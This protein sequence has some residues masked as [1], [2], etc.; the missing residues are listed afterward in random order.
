MVIPKRGSMLYLCFLLQIL[1]LVYVR[2]FMIHSVSEAET[3][4][5]SCV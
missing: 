5:L 3:Y 4:V 2:F 1:V